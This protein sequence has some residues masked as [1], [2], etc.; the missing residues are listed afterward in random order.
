MSTVFP[1]GS[2]GTTDN[3]VEEMRNTPRK[4]RDTVDEFVESVSR[5]SKDHSLQAPIVWR[6]VYASNN[7]DDCTIA[8]E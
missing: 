3:T 7:A 4:V 6:N 2:K 1:L 5:N 8:R